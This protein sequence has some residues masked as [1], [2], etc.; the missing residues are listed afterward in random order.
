MLRSA[1]SRL[2]P[3][4]LA[5]IALAVSPARADSVP[6]PSPAPSASPQ[7]SVSADVTVEN[8]PATRVRTLT[9]QGTYTGATYGPGNARG[10]QVIT[11]LASF[12]VGKSLLRLSLPRIQTI[13]GVSSGISDMQAF[14]LVQHPA[15]SG[16]TFAG[17]FMQLPTASKPQFGTGKWLV[18]PAAAYF[19][20]FKPRRLI[21]GVLLQTAFSVAGPSSRP[22]Q[23]AITFLPFGSL[24]LGHGWYL[25]LPESPWVFDLQ[26]GRSLIAL[27]LG[28]GRTTRIG[29]DPVL[30]AVS[31]ETT[32][33]RSNTPNAQKNT[34][35]LTFTVITVSR[36][37][38]PGTK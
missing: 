16:A 7:S 30:V 12:Y 15:R 1:V 24:D 8:D 9:V 32:V 20:A 17:V 10:S 6:A 29:R 27:G 34:V 36:S 22:N 3:V 18:G 23:S 4:S 35:R 5:L 31:D 38:R 19:F 26:Q 13:N 11:R 2:V 37:A 21:A 25:K 28:I 14:Y 33:L